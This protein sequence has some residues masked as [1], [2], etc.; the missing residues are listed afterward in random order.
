ML[1]TCIFNDGE[2]FRHAI[3]NLFAGPSGA[4]DP[5]RDLFNRNDYLPKQANW[6]GFFDHLVQQSSGKGI[7]ARLA[8]AYWYVVGEVDSKP[9][10]LP[11]DN[12]D[13]VLGARSYN[14]EELAK[15]HQKNQRGIQQLVNY[16]KKQKFSPELSADLDGA[17]AVLNEL[18]RRKTAI[19]KRFQWF[20]T[21][22]SGIAHKHH[23]I[24]FRRSGGISYDLFTA[25]LG[26]EKTTDV[27]L[28]VDMMR[29]KDIYDVAV[30]VSGDQDF[31]PAARAVK[32]LGKTVVNV[33]F[34][35]ED[36]N[37]LP[38]RARRLNE[39]VDWSVE[40]DFNVF[41]DFLFPGLPETRPDAQR[42]GG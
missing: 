28:A 21:L 33:S 5:S 42:M 10:W 38:S 23:R 14:A 16:A 29:L 7:E 20:A 18:H 25:T 1:K 37:L 8:R 34:K 30:I 24:E 12:W 40:V 13:K 36:S 22:Q 11:T 41:R 4:F 3:C 17:S 31:L 15:W 39:A 19:E 27:N 32:D 2:N 9:N 6:A 35:T 26:K